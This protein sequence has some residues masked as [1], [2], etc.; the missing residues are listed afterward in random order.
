MATVQ[1]KPRSTALTEGPERTGHRALLHALGVQRSDFSKPFIAVA[2]SFNEIVPGC[3]HQRELAEYVKGG[4]REAGGV[5]FEFNT[6]TIC[7]GLAQGHE[8]MRYSLPARE[9]IAASGELMLQAHRF[10][11]VVFLSSCDKTTPGMLMAAARVNIPAI[12]V[13]SGSMAAGE[14]GGEK[15]TLS[16]MREYAG[17]YHTGLIT[18][19]ELALVESCACPTPGSCA[20]MGTANTM[21]CLTEVLGMALP[22]SATAPATSREKRELAWEAGRLIV[23]LVRKDLRPRQIMSQEALVNAVRVDVAIGGS[24]NAV[25][26]LP[27]LAEELG[28]ELTLDEIDDLSR[29]TPY[30][31]AINPSSPVNTVPDLHDAGGIPAVLQALLPLLHRECLTVSDQT[32]GEIAASAEIK[33]PEV[34]QSLENPIS[35]QGGLAVLKGNLAP[36]GAVC[37]KSAIKPELWR[38]RGTAKVFD[39]MEEA[40]Q[41]VVTGRIGKGDVIVIRYEGP[42]G[43]PGMREMHMITSIIAGMGLDVPLVTDGRFSGSTRGPNIGHVSPEAALGGPIGVVRDGDRIE[44]DIGA[45]RI[46]LDLPDDKLKERLADF[47]PRRDKIPAQGFLSLYARCVGVASRGAVLK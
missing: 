35:P 16:K 1:E 32:I 8:G 7:D 18:E 17:R 23:H 40:I 19:E 44:L 5:P 34:I 20:M 47:E 36:E 33:R 2:S 12:F 39:S 3:V 30:L 38:Y 28:Q 13:P 15:L 37:K 21:A 11:G 14:Y 22:G 9:V 10:D 24:T 6:I 25:L 46:H 41:A 45:G 27:A 4:I 42:V 29:T 31:A 43:G 26:H